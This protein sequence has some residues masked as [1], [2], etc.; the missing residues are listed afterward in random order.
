MARDSWGR[1]IDYL[2]LSVTDRCNFRCAYCL[3]ASFA[4]FADHAATLTDDELVRAVSA[5]AAL[6][7]KRLRLTGGEPLVRPGIVALTRRL[8]QVPGVT[9]L[10]MSTNGALLAPLAGELAR[11]GLRRVNVSLD[12]LDPERFKALTRFGELG[13]VLEG[14]DAAE[15]AGLAPLKLNVVVVRGLNDGEVPDFVDLAQGRALHVRFIELMP[16][17]DAGFYSEGRRVPYAELRAAC[18]ALEA[19]PAAELPEGGGPAR[20]WRRRGARGTVGFISALSCGFCED[21]N[22]VRLTAQGTL[23]AC[24][25]GAE[26]V[27]LR[28]PL[29]SGLDA[30]GL[31]ALVAGALARKP[32]S[33]DMAARS[34]GAGSRFMCQTGG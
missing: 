24:L 23:H 33:H 17:G 30:R 11:A 25:D 4:G 15:G 14:L 3:P 32:K 13:A 21:C 31:G 20:V 27:D 2:R 8:A 19:V 26:G 16:M 6:G 1:S 9:D 28:G 5:F 7:F 10:S 22:R 18:G 34:V 12:T 29:R